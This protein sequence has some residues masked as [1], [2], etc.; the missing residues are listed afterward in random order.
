MQRTRTRL[1]HV[2]RRCG[3]VLSPAAVVLVAVACSPEL[4]GAAALK[5]GNPPAYQPHADPLVNPPA[6][7]EPFP[8]EDPARAEADPTLLR[9]LAASPTTLNPIFARIWPDFYLADLLFLSPFQRNAELEIVVNDEVVESFAESADGTVATL[10]LRPGLR[11]QDGHPWTAHDVEF[12]WRAI[13][14][15]RVPSLAFDMAAGQLARVRALDAHTVEYLLARPLAT[16]RI[17]MS[18]PVIPEHVFGRTEERARDPSLRTSDYYN[19]HAR[20]DVVGSGHYR[21]LEWRENDKLVLERWEDSP[22]PLPRPYFRRQVL[23]IQPDPNLALLLFRRGEL[24]EMALTPQQFATQTADQA[25]RSGGVK[26]YGAR[27]MVTSIAFNMDGSNPFFADVRVRRAMAYAFDNAR[28]LRD[29]YYGLYPPSRGIFDAAHWAFDHQVEP[30]PHDPAIAAQLLDEAGW[31]RSEDDGWRYRQIGS[32]PV[33]FELELILGQS[34]DAVRLATYLAE[35]L[36]GVGVSLVPRV[37]EVTTILTLIQ[38]HEFQA[39]IDVDEVT[40]DPDLW[41]QRFTTEAYRHGLNYYGYS[42]PRVD[43]L[44]RLGREE[45]DRKQRAAYYREIQRILYEEQA[46]LFVHEF[47]LLWAFDR[48]LRGVDFSAAGPFGFHPSWRTWWMER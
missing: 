45:R 46:A 4:P 16:S 27:R 42:N 41:A 29:V 13:T 48:R 47:S 23:K 26:A 28:F 24:H 8:V 31:I 15:E 10:L 14:D 33:K 17:A 30:I 37:V 22:S 38:N 19:R 21:L 12:T 9:H 32:E 11:W 25:F 5:G 6:L 20:S 3:A 39:Y 36:R 7:S 35:D 1:P 44:F 40:T 2:L 43:E 34:P 18:F